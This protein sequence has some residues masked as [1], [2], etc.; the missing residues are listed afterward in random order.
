LL[1]CYTITATLVAA[2][3]VGA[4]VGI[5][6]AVM[7]S[8]TCFGALVAAGLRLGSLS[9]STPQIRAHEE[10]TAAFSQNVQ[11]SAAGLTFVGK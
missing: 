8:A 6:P 9:S 1:T 10:K 2:G 4:R 3:L 7:T 11:P 5:V